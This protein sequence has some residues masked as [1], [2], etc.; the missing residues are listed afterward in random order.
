[1]TYEQQA[2]NFLSGCG[3]TMTT[4]FLR[5]G[6]HF[7]GEKESR[8]IYH[9]VIERNG[10]KMEFDFGQSIN[11]SYPNKR[12]FPSEYDVLACLQKYEPYADIW[13]FAHEY[14]Y[15]INSR[16]SFNRVDMIH[17]AVIKEYCD[18]QRLFGDVMDELCEIC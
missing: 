5:H 3:A 11:Y 8:D 7:I 13:E 9:I 18:V 12:V 17:M 1:M 15:E 10:R 14:G 6:P 4:T 16:E 2:Q